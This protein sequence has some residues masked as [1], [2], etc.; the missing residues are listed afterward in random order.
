MIVPLVLLTVIADGNE[1]PI[2]LGAVANASQ[3]EVNAQ[4][5]FAGL[6]PCFH[7]EHT[8]DADFAACSKNMI[9]TF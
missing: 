8:T 1:N 4:L 3:D 5:F 7:S 2:P 9:C 6:R